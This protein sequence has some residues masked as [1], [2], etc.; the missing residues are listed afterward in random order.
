MNYLIYS[1]EDDE[2]I[3]HIISIAL[4]NVGYQ[5]E[6]FATYLSFKEKFNKVKPDMILLDLMLPDNDGFSILKEIRKDDK[7]NDIDIIIVSAK[8]QTIDKIDGFNLGADDYIE[9]PFDVLELIS[10]VNAKSRKK[11]INSTL[12]V[13]G[14]K[15]D[16]NKR[17]VLIDDKEVKFTNSEFIILYSLIKSKNNIVSRDELINKI[18]GNDSAVETRTIDVHI[19][20]IRDKLKKYGKNIISIYGIGYT[21]KDE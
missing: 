7:N 13:N 14:I 9:K 2:N 11:N 12:N 5:I 15:I 18:W 19:K 20:S 3:S 10:R 6:T 4:N 1:L 17:N 8:N 21:Y 16:E